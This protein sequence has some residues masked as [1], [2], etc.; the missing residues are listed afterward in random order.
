MVKPLK[1]RIYK[2]KENDRRER[3]KNII[4]NQGILGVSLGLVL[5][6]KDKKVVGLMG[7]GHEMIF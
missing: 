1:N 5:L 3:S 4:N 6:G 7:F 2:N